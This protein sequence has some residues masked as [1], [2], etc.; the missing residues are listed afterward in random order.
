[1]PV[2]DLFLRIPHTPGSAEAKR[3]IAGAAADVKAGSWQYLFASDFEWR[4]NWLIFRVTA[5]AQT[6]QGAIDVEEEFVELRAQ[7]PFVIRALTERFVPIVRN[8]GQKLL[9]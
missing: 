6:V 2:N 9:K 7:L 3:R 4:V 5:L 1:M 8:A